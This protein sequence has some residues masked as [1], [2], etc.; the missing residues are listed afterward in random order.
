MP[1]QSAHAPPHGIFSGRSVSN[2]EQTVHLTAAY[3]IITAPLDM[4]FVSRALVFW[5][6]LVVSVA[7]AAQ[8]RPLFSSPG[9]AIECPSLSLPAKKAA[10]AVDKESGPSVVFEKL[11]WMKGHRFSRCVP[12]EIRYLLLL[13]RPGP[14]MGFPHRVELARWES[15]VPRC[16]EESSVPFS[17]KWAIPRMCSPVEDKRCGHVNQEKVIPRVY[18]TGRG[19]ALHHLLLPRRPG[20]AVSPC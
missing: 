1:I 5:A 4:S 9:L 19:P 18:S 7:R 20:L 16:S 12:G 15:G 11:A 14:A 10:S 3:S 8:Q 2:S 17:R 13:R 6:S